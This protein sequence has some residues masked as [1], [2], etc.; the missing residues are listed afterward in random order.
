MGEALE[1]IRAQERAST[2]EI[3]LF[4]PEQ[5]E[6]FWPSIVE[7][8]AKVPHL[9]QERHTLQGLRYATLSRGVQVWGVSD[10]EMWK[11]ISM[12]QLLEYETGRALNVLMLFGQM[13]P[14]F[15]DILAAGFERFC[16]HTGCVRVEA[17]VRPG[18]EPLLAKFGARRVGVA[19][20]KDI[21]PMRMQ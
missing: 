5:V 2:S 1:A 11:L 4:T 9:W 18:L 17:I 13:R 15:I 19:M 3:A 12:S 16:Q 21:Y 10:G 20:V 6:Q 7:E 8:L 14:E